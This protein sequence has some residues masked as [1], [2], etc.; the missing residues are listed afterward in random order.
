MLLF[1][2]LWASH[3]YAAEVVD[4][5]LPVVIASSEITAMGGAGIGFANGATGLSYTPSAPALR[6]V[7]DTGRKNATGN[8]SSF[9]SPAG[10]GGDLSNAGARYTGDNN[11]L[12]VDMGATGRIGRLG[13]GIGLTGIQVSGAGGQGRIADGRFALATGALD[14]W[15]AGGVAARVMW[16]EFQQGD[17][18]EQ[19]MGLGAE[20]GVSVAPETHSFRLGVAARSPVRATPDGGGSLGISAVQLPWQVALGAGWANAAARVSVSEGRG[21]RIGADVVLYGP[22]QDG[23][24]LV[25]LLAGEVVDRGHTISLSPRLGG[26]VEVIPQRLRLRAGSYVEPSRS[27]GRDP[28]LHGTAGGEVR[29]FHVRM[30]WGY[31]DHDVSLISAFDVSAR[32]RRMGWLGISVWDTGW[33]NTVDP[34]DEVFEQR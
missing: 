28:R 8:F 19:F 17:V 21:V 13:G 23:V 29:L 25:P 18:R 16:V 11:E 31:I 30:L 12:L 2:L 33:V 3:L 32:Y 20:V 34:A 15:V 5:A 22:V 7:T 24:S 27:V 9:W 26:E 6:R 14:G 4:A 1:C 10:A